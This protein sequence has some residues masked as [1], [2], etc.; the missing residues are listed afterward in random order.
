[1]LDNCILSTRDI[2]KTYPGVVALKDVSIDFLPGEIHALVGE[3][4]AGKSTLVKV[5]SGAIA[6]DG[7]QVMMDGHAFESM[8][9][10]KAQALGIE[11]IYQEFNLVPS[12]SVAENIFLGASEG[13]GVFV[14]FKTMQRK[15]AQ[16]F[17]QLQVDIDPRRPVEELSVAQM[18]LVEIAKSLSRS[19]RVLI[20][21]EPT[22]PL[23]L[24]ET[25]I[26]FTLIRSL[27][28]KGVTIIYISHR[29]SEI[30]ELSDRITVMR[31]GHKVAT[32][33]T[34]RTSRDE[35]IR[36]MVGRELSET[37]PRRRDGAGEVVFE[38]KGLT[39]E[40]P[41]DISF[42]LRRGEILGVAGLV[43]AGR[44]ELMR[45]IFG[46]DPV[47]KGQIL[48]DG[49]PV[50]IKSPRQAVEKGIG[51]VPEDRK[52]HGVLVDLSIR[53]NITLSILKRLSRG[54]F[55]MG[56]RERQVLNRYRDSLR[57][58]TPSFAQLVK[59]L[60]GGNQQKVALSKWL[61]SGSNI[62]IF[63][64]PTRGIDVGAK[65]EIY[66]LMDQ[67]ARQGKSIM[68][69]SSE[70]EELLGMSD[71]VIVLREGRL[72]GGIDRWEDFSQERVMALASGK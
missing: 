39:G 24:R 12:L 9:P 19:A 47:L 44:T 61:A 71:R 49:R 34:A 7:G 43:G 50:S 41:K 42:A 20:M 4:G 30:F 28:R 55:V 1:M 70:M 69:V 64:E 56:G 54:G 58:K 48:L 29:F 2:T 26:L 8:Q 63:D 17:A 36:L 13:K 6:P 57:I 14:D 23:T 53:E 72:A 59:N 32:L 21:D 18:Q 46:A 37:Y 40:R 38:V 27:K 11:V 45:M 66:Q 62:L 51:Y 35:M 31:D 33:Q 52:R 22:A 5:L 68:M 60:S 65:Q 3:N 16:L 67:L 10:S 15:A 25:Q